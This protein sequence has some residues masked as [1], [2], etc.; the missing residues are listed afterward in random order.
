VKTGT[1]TLARPVEQV[2]VA[3]RAVSP[4]GH[5]RQGT[6]FFT[7]IDGVKGCLSAVIGEAPREQGSHLSP[8]SLL[9]RSSLRRVRAQCC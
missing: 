4:F 5:Y 7:D 6:G 1:P 2:N 3:G 9:C 8:S